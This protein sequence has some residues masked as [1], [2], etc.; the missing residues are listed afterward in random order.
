VS[1]RPLRSDD[2]PFEP[3]LALA[4][5]GRRAEALDALCLL[6]REG[7]DAGRRGD[8]ATLAF[9]QVA[10]RAEAAGDTA[11][12][13]RAL[14]EALRL[15]PRFA[16]LHYRRGCVLLGAQDGAGARA[17]LARAL[18][19]NPEFLAARLELA[20][21]DAR[22]GFLSEALVALRALGAEPEVAMPGAF[23]R[24]LRSLERADWDEAAALLRSAIRA[25]TPVVDHALE[26]HRELA[27]QGDHAGALAALREA[28]LVHPG[29]PDLHAVLGTCELEAGLLDDALA[30]L[31]RALELNP[32]YHG[33]RVQLARVL[34]ALGELEQARDQVALVLTADPDHPQAGE[35]AARWTR[36][37][38]AGSEPVTPAR[39]AS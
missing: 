3:A 34:E 20:L 1:P 28:I 21:L 16:D 13:L 11:T 4:R 33:A 32:D 14:D 6:T 31:A 39:K 29:Y 27:G 8:A 23:Q 5:A 12:A 35:L 36:R 15:K 7:G 17:A 2:A 22:Q 24:G 10:R 26:H 38:G 25:A 30:S 19:I 37:R 18:A 9:V